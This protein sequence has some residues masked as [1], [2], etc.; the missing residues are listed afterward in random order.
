MKQFVITT[1]VLSFVVVWL[2]G[3][4]SHQN[5]RQAEAELEQQQ[6]QE[7]QTAQ[8][9]HRQALAI[10]V[11]KASPA[12]EQRHVWVTKH[13][14]R[15]GRHGDTPVHI[16]FRS[17]S[18]DPWQLVGT[19]TKL[20][21]VPDL[22]LTAYHIFEGVPGYYGCRKIGPNEFT[23]NEPVVP[24]V[25][26]KSAENADDAVSCRIDEDS[27]DYPLI[28]APVVTNMFRTWAQ[29]K[30]YEMKFAPAKIRFNTYPEQTIQ[31]FL[32][33]RMESASGAYYFFFD[34]VI[35]PGESGT[36]AIMEG[37]A[38]NRYLVVTRC[39]PID[40]EVYD[41]LPLDAKR[42]MKWS[43]EKLYGIGNLII[44]EPQP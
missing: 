13:V 26:C 12:M 29:G 30:L 39:Q 1:I 8:E 38:D 40:Q 7:E 16:L 18:K 9:I 42:L 20:G 22:V 5:R 17:N 24:I 10:G 6:R 14:Y 11:F 35:E 37:E 41:K 36:S 23:G 31:N 4:L 15:E 28:S 43:P 2:I 33:V 19:G 25:E 27:P 44:V 3:F 32:Q 21:Q 34:W